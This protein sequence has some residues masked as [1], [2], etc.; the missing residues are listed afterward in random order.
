MLLDGI[1]SIFTLIS[2]F[3]VY[4]AFKLGLEIYKKWDVIKTNP[5]TAY[6]KR[7]VDMA[8]F[9]IA[10]PPSVIVHELFHALAVLFFGGEVVG[11]GFFFFIGF[12]S[13]RGFYTPFQS[14][15]ISLAGTLGSLL[16]GVLVWALLRQNKSSTWRYFGLRTLHFQIILSLI[17]Y[18]LLTA[19]TRFGDWATIY[20]FEATPFWSGLTAVF[21]AAILLWFWWFDRAG[22]FEQLSFPTT[23]TEHLYEQVQTQL[24]QM[25]H[26]VSLQ[27]TNI[28]LLRQGGA[29]N[30]AKEQMNRLALANPNNSEVLYERALLNLTGKQLPPKSAIADLNS[31][32][33]YG[34]A[35]KTKAIVANQVLGQYYLETGD[36]ETAVQ[37]YDQAIASMSNEPNLLQPDKIQHQRLALL[38][39]LRSK[40]H[41]T[42]RNFDRAY[43][44]IQEAIKLAQLNNDQPAI[45]IYKDELSI[46]EQNAGYSFSD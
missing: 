22:R 23:Q 29:L 46:L 8:A 5:M 18:P 26:D 37:H 41:R 15:F 43:L 30:R 44:D 6:K 4:R 33:S 21:H 40:A 1:G 28:S 10:V 14:W 32:L 45:N 16:F 3:Y 17:N 35:D 25:P 38:Y 19:L 27:L 42:L 24:K 31:A 9:L 7:L 2:L 13:H 12:V 11:G 20:N 34:L 39:S 36:G